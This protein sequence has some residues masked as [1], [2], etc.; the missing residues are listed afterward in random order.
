MN[1]RFVADIVYDLIKDFGGDIRYIV[2]NSSV[3]NEETGKRAIDKTLYSFTAAIAPQEMVRKFVQDIG[4]LAADK[5]FT[6]G[7]LNDYNS[8]LIIVDGEDVT[9]NPDLDGYV[10]Y[11]N[12]RYSKARMT[13]IGDG[14]AYIFQLKKVM[15]DLPNDIK[16]LFVGDQIDFQEGENNELT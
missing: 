4:Y 11:D 15:G 5:N 16:E 14:V 8:V 10:I 13:R 2:I 12:Q 7:G 6:Y 9:F 3:L 1:T